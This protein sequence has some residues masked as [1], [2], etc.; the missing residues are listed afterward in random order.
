[1]VRVLGE[2]AEL[3][4]LISNHPSLRHDGNDPTDGNNYW[5]QALKFFESP[6]DVEKG[7]LLTAEAALDIEDAGLELTFEWKE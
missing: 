7:R 4:I 5:K 1:M 6:L 2:I 3:F